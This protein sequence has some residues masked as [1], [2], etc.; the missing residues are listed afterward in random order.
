[1]FVKNLTYVPVASLQAALEV[2]KEGS[3][4]KMVRPRRCPPGST[5]VDPSSP[6]A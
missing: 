6:L 1:V 5:L 4:F 2:M 3:R